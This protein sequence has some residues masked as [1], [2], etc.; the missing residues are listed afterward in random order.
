M[1]YDPTNESL[2]EKAQSGE[3]VSR[4]TLIL[5]PAI[6]GEERKRLLAER[7]A[8]LRGDWLSREG[9]PL[10][11]FTCDR[12]GKPNDTTEKPGSLVRC[13]CGHEMKLAKKV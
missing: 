9:Q 7:E 1:S 6:Q 2:A 4:H 5:D 11:G 13:D 10:R 3:W 12:C 8:Y